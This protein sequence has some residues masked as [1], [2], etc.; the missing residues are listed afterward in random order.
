VAY[1]PTAAA[2]P[3]AASSR[4]GGGAGAQ[5]RSGLPTGCRARTGRTFRSAQ[6]KK[7]R[8]VALTFDDGPAADTPAFLSVLER[9]RVRATFF[10]IGAQVPGHGSVLRR[11][12]RDGDAIGD[13]TLTHANLAGLRPDQVRHQLAATADAIHQAV[14]YR[15]CVMRPPY[16]AVNRRVVR[17]AA[18]EHLATVL[19]NVDPRDW[20]RPG[21]GAIQHRVLSAVHPGSIVIMHDGGG[22]RGQTLTALPRIIAAL[23]RRGYRFKTVPDLLGFRTLGGGR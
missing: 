23:R 9:V 12:L 8:L 22:P 2:R 6:R 17:I 5:S 19:W 20:S 4:S 14:G 10:Q 21:T 7:G 15:P 16:G 11:M 1:G 3:S 13:H 18:N